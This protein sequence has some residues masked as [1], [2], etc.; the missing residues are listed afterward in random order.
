[1]VVVLLLV[2]FPLCLIKDLEKFSVISSFAVLFYA[3]FVIRMVLEALPAL[4]DGAWSM[5]VTWWRPSGLPIVCMALSCQTQLFCVIDC[6]RDA[7]VSR[8]DAVVSGAVNF[9]SAM[10]AGVGTFGYVA[11]FS[12]SL[13]GDV[14]VELESSFLTQ[15]LKLAFMLS[16]A[17]SIPLMLFPARIARFLTWCYGRCSLHV[18]WFTEDFMLLYSFAKL[19]RDGLC[20]QTNCELPVSHAMRYSTFH[21]LTFVILLFNLSVALL[22]PNVEFVLGLTG[23]LIGSLVSIIIPSILYLA[24]MKN[25]DHYSVSYA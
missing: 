4:W 16:I 19:Y 14:L 15:L 18:L 25:R 12:R 23:S 2:I 3:I 9:C 7:S 6:I 20:V 1:M 13:H 21:V 5:H 8:V 17:I 22:I 24:V 11:F 10:Y